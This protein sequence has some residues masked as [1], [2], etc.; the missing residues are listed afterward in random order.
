[1]AAGTT[2]DHALDLWQRG[3][4]VIPIPRPRPGA[5]PGTP[6]DGKVPALAWRA[7]QTRRPTEDELRRW[8]SA[9]RNLGVITGR[10]SGVIV[11]D[12]D[13]PEAVRWIV[14][15]LPR[16]PWQTRTAR[17]IHAWYR[18]PGTLVRNRARIETRDGRLAID[19]RGDGGFVVGPGSVH[20]SGVEYER[21]GDWSAPREN[22]PVFWLGW[23]QRPG[24]RHPT[25]PPSSR[26][27][28][29]VVE[30]ARRY[31]RAT[32]R[33]TIGRGS[34]AA[35]FIAACRLTRGFGIEA[36]AAV[37]LLQEWAP[38][39]D[40]WWLTRKVHSA[41]QYGEEPIGSLR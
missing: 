10:V 34:D 32:P 40:A 25:R 31:L 18:H 7:Y 9:E 33:P 14:R 1:M 20:A 39:F 13:S 15:H 21:G 2:L 11:I 3:L 30:R 36:T 22:L 37:A 27:S 41:I 19:V 17:G 16:T 12:A 28:G 23:L 24:P 4:S 5:A 38:D 26:P 29:D 35:T 6:G 8:F